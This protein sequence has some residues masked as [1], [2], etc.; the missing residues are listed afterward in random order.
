MSAADGI[1]LSRDEVKALARSR[2]R[3][4]QAK[5][6]R[7]NGIRH[8]IDAHGWPVVLR[9]SVEAD[10]SVKSAPAWKSNKAA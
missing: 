6:L 8:Y 5:F 10:S 2:T 1:C 4:G 9:S 7:Q 3:D